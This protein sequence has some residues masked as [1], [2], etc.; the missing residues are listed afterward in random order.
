MTR[1]RAMEHVSASTLA[2]AQR[3]SAPTHHVI[4]TG[5]AYRAQAGSLRSQ[6][7]ARVI[8]VGQ[9][10]PLQTLLARAARVDGDLGFDPATVRSG[11]VLHQGAKPAVYLLVGRRS[12]GDFVVVQ[13]IPHAGERGRRIA[14]GEVVMTREGR[15]RVPCL[16]PR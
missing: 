11:L 16:A 12:S 10:V 8:E 5:R 15:L 7:L 13:D 2:E 3:R 1:H 14:A 6:A 4:W 9:P